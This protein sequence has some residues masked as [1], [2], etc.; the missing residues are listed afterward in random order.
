[1]LLKKEKVIQDIKRSLIDV[2][3]ETNGITINDTLELLGHHPELKCNP[4][5]EKSLAEFRKLIIGFHNN[6][7]DISTILNHPFS[8][9]FFGFF[10]DF[11]IP[12]HE[13][14]IHLT[15]SLSADFIY[16][17]LKVLLEGPTRKV[18]EDK[19]RQVYGDD[20]IPIKSIADIDR[21]IRLKEGEQFKT[22]LKILYL[23][24]LILTTREAHV[25]AAYHMSS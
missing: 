12:Y 1:M 21:L 10:K 18:Y 11:P 25:A 16:P 7:V 17:R 23:S 8:E 19:I 4:L 24:K 5:V 6:E 13:E 20:S 22:Y 9:A 2:I 14:H 15:G 3:S